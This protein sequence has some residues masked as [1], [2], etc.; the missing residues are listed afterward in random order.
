MRQHAH[1]ARVLTGTMDLA[2]EVHDC[3][4]LVIAADAGPEFGLLVGLFP[5]DAMCAAR[6]RKGDP[7]LWMFCRTGSC[8]VVG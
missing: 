8:A 3:Q 5:I 2:D 1:R 6:W 4:R 7:E